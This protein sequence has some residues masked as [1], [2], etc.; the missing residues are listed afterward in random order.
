MSYLRMQTPFS[1]LPRAERGN[2]LEYKANLVLRIKLELH[3]SITK[4]LSLMY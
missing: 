4:N 3:K 2:E 1:S